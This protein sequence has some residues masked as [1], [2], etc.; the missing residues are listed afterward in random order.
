[1]RHTKLFIF[2]A[3]LFVGTIAF[4]AATA[5][6]PSVRGQDANVET[7]GNNTAGA[8]LV[9]TSGST[10]PAAGSTSGHD[11]RT[12]PSPATAGAWH[13]EAGFVTEAAQMNASEVALSD[14]AQRRASREEVKRYAAELHRDHRAATEEL[15]ALAS[16][17]NWAFPQSMDALQAQALQA[18]ERAETG[19]VFDR[20]YIDAMITSHERALASFTV[21]STAAGDADLKA[22]AAKHLPTLQRHLDHAR[23]LK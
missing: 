15:K 4:F 14:V 19:P 17:K 21:A 23:S 5:N 8:P 13:G 11:G 12:G 16:R 2:L 9:G 1:M 20:A 18:L 7:R 10:D 6:N 22:F 3:V